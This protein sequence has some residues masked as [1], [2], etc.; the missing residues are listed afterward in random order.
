MPKTDICFS[1]LAFDAKSHAKSLVSLRSPRDKT[2]RVEELAEEVSDRGWWLRYLVSR[3]PL[4]RASI[5]VL[6]L[7]P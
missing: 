3:T 6:N 4:S 7:K 5:K 1:F 2:F